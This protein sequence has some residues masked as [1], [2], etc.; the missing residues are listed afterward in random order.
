MKYEGMGRRFPPK[1]IRRDSFQQGHETK[2]VLFDRVKAQVVRDLLLVD[3]EGKA[4]TGRKIDQ[5][6][7]ESGIKENELFPEGARVLNIG[8]PWQ[9]LD[10]EGVVNLEYE[11]G[12]EADFVQNPDRFLDSVSPELEQMTLL[13]KWIEESDEEFAGEL[14]W[15]I[16]SV[17]EYV[18]RGVSLEDY[19]RVAKVLYDITRLISEHHGNDDGRGNSKELWYAAMRLARGFEDISYTKNVIEPAIT[20]EVLKQRGLS[21]EDEEVL[22][23]QLIEEFRGKKKY[24]HAE[25]VKGAFPD[26]PFED[27]SFDRVVASWSVSAHMFGAMEVP[28]FRVVWQELDRIIKK[29]GAAY[30]WPLDYGSK[31]GEN[32]AL[33]LQEHRQSGGDVGILHWFPYGGFS[34]TEKPNIEW[35]D[36]VEMDDLPG[37]LMS[38]QTLVFLPRGTQ[39]SVRRRIESSLLNTIQGNEE[40]GAQ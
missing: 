40:E 28:Q 19:E 34:G 38:C 5:Y 2:D 10:K 21:D 6:E 39:D 9:V 15:R 33:T 17:Q 20:K 31:D 36:D 4:L 13:V 3:Q 29:D 11:T 12:E 22:R 30:L 32:I 14:A 16:R 1:D 23:H 8:D 24:R 27:K 18:E 25:P 35:I 37:K 26:T 7:D